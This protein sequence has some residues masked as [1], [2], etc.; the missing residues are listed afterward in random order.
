MLSDFQKQKIEHLFRFYDQDHSGA[1]EAHDIDTIA[2]RFAEEFHWRIGDEEDRRFRSLF[3]Q[4]WRRLVLLFDED[5][6]E[7][8]TLNEFMAAYEKNLSQPSEYKH[9]VH[10]FIDKLFPIIDSDKDD[11]WTQKE[12]RR[13]YHC[14]GQSHNEA[15]QAFVAMDLNGDGLL[16]KNEIYQHFEDFHLSQDPGKVGNHFFGRLT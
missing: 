2:N 13:F 12:F 11:A 7:K 15:D 1:I 6:N 16:Q 14:F 8:V 9:N 5:Q 4:V 10:P 3:R